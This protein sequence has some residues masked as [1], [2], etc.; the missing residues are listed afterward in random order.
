V[1]VI[2]IYHLFTVCGDVSKKANGHK[3][4]MSFVKSGK[5]QMVLEYPLK[6]YEKLLF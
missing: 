4:C 5:E 1:V 3:E 6:I 2:A